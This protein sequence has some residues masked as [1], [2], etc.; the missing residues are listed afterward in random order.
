MT[1]EDAIR[2]VGEI[3]RSRSEDHAVDVTALTRAMLEAARIGKTAAFLP[4]WGFAR[5]ADDDPL[6][7]RAFSFVVAREALDWGDGRWLAVLWMVTPP[8][9]LDASAIQNT[10]TALQRHAEVSADERRLLAGEIGPFLLH[11]AEINAALLESVLDLVGLYLDAGTLKYLITESDGLQ[12][13]S[14]FKIGAVRELAGAVARIEAEIREVKL[15]AILPGV[16]PALH[17]WRKGQSGALSTPWPSFQEHV[18]DSVRD[19]LDVHARLE[20]LTADAE[21]R[22]A[23]VQE[24]RVKGK[25]ATVGR[26]PVDFLERLLHAW[27]KSYAD[28]RRKLS[29]LEP[30]TMFALVPAEGSYV[31]RTQVETKLP[32]GDVDSRTA[33]A[34][35]SLA[36]DEPGDLSSLFRLAAENGVD[37]EISMVTPGPG[38]VRKRVVITHHRARSVAASNDEPEAVA[39]VAEE[40]V[41]LLDAAS[42]RTGK[43]EVVPDGSETVVH[44]T[45]GKT[46]VGLLL[47]KTIG[48]RYRFRFSQD[49]ET[50]ARTVEEVSALASSQGVAS[51]ATRELLAPSPQIVPSEIIPQADSLDRIIEIVE[52]VRSGVPVTPTTISLSDRHIAYHLTAARVL[53]LV[54]EGRELLPA[55]A[56]LVC[57]P[58][59]RRFD[60]LAIQFEVSVVGRAWLA[61]AKAAGLKDLDETTAEEFLKARSRLGPSVV[62]RRART[63][64]RW[65]KD[66]RPWQAP[67]AGRL[68]HD[69]LGRRLRTRKLAPRMP[70]APRFR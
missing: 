10:L 53:L 58:T 46:R 55:G 33:E 24:V 49:P 29:E 23:P 16:A 17:R 39:T 65:A 12:L 68:D 8:Y 59:A 54:S 50:S 14:R 15:P 31:I 27:R 35:S 40:V 34:L 1:A 20:G 11:A 13:V 43:V 30:P 37:L 41:G 2:A 60:H 67:A 38:G 5:L 63:L 44:A 32:E 56:T 26:V 7:R 47:N 52:V 3:I 64:R 22:R 45:A 57:L 28:A 48:E 62:V 42:H 4:L 21:K 70:L 51:V 61:W 18:D 66:L 69:P 25:W 19:F 6:V 36:D 9:T